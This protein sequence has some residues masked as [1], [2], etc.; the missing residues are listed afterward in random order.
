VAALTLA[1]GAASAQTAPG[2]VEDGLTL[3]RARAVSV[4]SKGKGQWY[5]DKFDLS[6]LD[7][8]VPEQKVSRKL[9]IWGITILATVCSI[10]HIVFAAS[11][12]L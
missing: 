5:T 7:T 3:Q 11:A 1:V 4:T 12:G 6:G 10:F 8:Y 9:R 2:P